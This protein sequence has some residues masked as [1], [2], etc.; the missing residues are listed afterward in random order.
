M[1]L[2]MEDILLA[3][4]KL[5]E[6]GE[7]E[8]AITE[9]TALVQDQPSAGA[10]HLRSKCYRGLG[11]NKKALE[12]LNAA[13]ELQP[14]N[15]AAYRDRA[16]LHFLSKRSDLAMIDNQLADK[17]AADEDL[18]DDVDLD[19]ESGWID[20]GEEASEADKLFDRVSDSRERHY[21]RHFGTIPS[22]VLKLN[23]MMGV[24]PGG[25]LVQI[26]ALRLPDAPCVTATLG[27][28]NPDMPATVRSENVVQEERTEGDKLLRSTSMRLVAR[29]PAHVPP[30]LAGYGYEVIVI[31]PEQNDWPT[32][33]LS[34]FVTNEINH[35]AGW[36]HRVE[37]EEAVLLKCPLRDYPRLKLLL[38]AAAPPIP[39]HFKLPNG[40]ARMLVATSITEAE[41]TFAQKRGAQALLEAM[42]IYGPGQ[43]SIIFRPSC[44]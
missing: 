35:D 6:K 31:T 20:S 8:K 24:W 43:T 4:A 10:L 19:E 28:T 12:D 23:N 11:D 37:A 15:P 26:Q 5:Y 21:E 9:L 30:G 27:L 13:I 40:T 36:L 2:T 17:Y 25:C 42:R 3:V 33:F 29:E 16:Q 41:Y 39:G 38:S 34:W 14:N 44:V 18:D 22:D 7:H 1:A 32:L